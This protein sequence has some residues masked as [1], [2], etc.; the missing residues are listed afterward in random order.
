[1]E[2]SLAR[3]SGPSFAPSK[4]TVYVSNLDFS[5]TNSDLHTIFSTTGKVG[6]VTVVKDREKR[7]S[8]GFA[9]ILYTNRED[10]RNTVNVMNG[11]V[12]NGRT[13]KVTIAKDNGR[14]RE[15]I[16][17][18]EYK[19]KSH[20]YE[21]GEEGHLSY[22]CPKNLL[23]ARE[24]PLK[25]KRKGQAEDGP[26]GGTWHESSSRG[27][28]DDSDGDNDEDVAADFEDEGWASIVAPRPSTLGT[29][30]PKAP[31]NSLKGPKKSKG[32]FSD[33]SGED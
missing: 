18:K 9:F 19:D 13:I 21:C 33:E 14:A 29:D 25:K 20:C 1:M 28:Q 7:E 22:E 2:D 27:W 15:F 11:K 17:R 3:G 23:G 6:K 12:L 10:A 32:Y 24:R 8:K 5:L 16:K 30:A 26:R 31:R 4:S